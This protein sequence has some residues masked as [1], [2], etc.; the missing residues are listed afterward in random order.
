MVI[1]PLL[2]AAYFCIS[3]AIQS[4]AAL[5]PRVE[6]L[7]VESVW[8]VPND[9]NLVIVASMFAALISSTIARNSSSG[10]CGTSSTPT[11]DGGQAAFAQSAYDSALAAIGN[12]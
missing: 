6:L 9:T 5:I 4:R 8:R 11:L 2:S 7:N 10:T 12:G 1:V 3:E